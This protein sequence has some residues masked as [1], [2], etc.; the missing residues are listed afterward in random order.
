MIR[1]AVAFLCAAMGIAALSC[2]ASA[3]AFPFVIPSNDSA[4]TAIDVSDLNPAPLDES[5][6]VS[7]RG[8]HFYDATGRRVRFVGTNF[9]AGACFP[10]K[11]DAAE[12]AARLHKYGFNCV[13]L[14]HMDSPW[15]E[16]NMFYVTGGSY[17]R[18]TDQLDPESLDRFD[19]LIYQ[20]KQHGIYVDINLHVGRG[21][22]AAD[23]FPD[24]DR[25][26]DMGKVV[27]YFE[28][29][30]IERQKLYAK[31]L[32]THYNPYT[33]MRY[34]D[35]PVVA[36]IEITNED[37]LLGSAD[38]LASL[39]PHYLGIL[40][41]GWNQ[42]LRDK[43]GSTER[44]VSAWNA[45]ARPLGENMLANPQLLDGTT[46]WTL[47]QH[48]GTHATMVTEAIEAGEGA[49]PG[50]AL[51]LTDLQLDDTGWHLQLHQVGLTLRE[52][53]MYTVSFAARSN[54]SRSLGVNVRLD[55]DPWTMAGLDIGIALTPEWQ[56]HSFTFIARNTVPGH[57]RLSFVFGEA[58]GDVFLADLSLRPG[59][60]Q[61]ELGPG[62]SL[63]AGSIRPASI[64][65]TPRGR[66]W[67]EYLMQVE[68]KF[69][70]GM[71]A[72][73]KE[74]LGARAS[75]ACTQASYG[76]L[77][78]VLRESRLDW[79]DMH[80]YWQHPWFP[81]RPWDSDDYRIGNT[82]MVR[83][84]YG[85]TLPGLAMHRV[86]GKPFTVSEYDHPAPNEWAA[87]M[88]PMIFA[89]AAWQDWD[90]VFTF[91]YH[92]DDQGWDR[93]RIEGFFDQ[94]AH[95]GKLAF[96]PAAAQMFLRGEVPAAPEAQT[97][98]VPQAQVPAIVAERRDYGFWSA[99]EGET[100]SGRDM[101][102]RRTNVRFVEN[103]GGVR[104]ERS[105]SAPGTPALVW[106]PRD[107]AG[108]LFTISSP[109]AKAV[110][111]FAGGRS[112]DVGGVQVAMQ[113]TPRNFLSLT[114]VAK[115]GKPIEASSSLIL[116][117]V[118]KVENA[119]LQW[120]AERT[121]AAQSWQRGPTMAETVAATITIPTTARRASVFALDQ[122]GARSKAVPS[123]LRAGRLTFR[124]G[125]E[126]GAV[127]Y[128]IAASR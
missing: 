78:G 34:V 85:G 58:A 57:V 47:E 26:D 39:P 48:E 93:D 100:V 18:K 19:Y 119:G 110:V 1:F 20:F 91:A 37:S 38:S 25:I 121:Y 120:N 45:E 35:D 69:T 71:Y 99:A 114:L 87:E 44:L 2:A 67:V 66:D 30:M 98:V 84:E 54:V 14:H 90:G 50:R 21:F 109:S 32:L 22:N 124:I 108:A 17:G 52:G 95:P 28:P 40:A 10:S 23:G 61:V 117:S 82:P 24:T 70:R 53:E 113:Q 76:G 63:E 49:P 46:G 4:K 79:V 42:F 13:R 88:V 75:V 73:I 68:E 43:Y 62:E 80:A 83:E 77:G 112:I 16:P 5:R 94:A 12:V 89:Y 51:R 7:V 126:D 6:R 15:S 9:A 101:V 8:D 59:G 92:G 118:D 127:W 104:V 105:G 55:Q 86:A 29:G 74:D 97:L 128:E 115:D 41:E 81:N 36:L 96:M 3:G 33:K 106:R 103:G 125:P 27:G 102:A 31:Q 107:P 56:R 116:T 60:G 122:T 111:G 72:Y 11:Q 64:A 65:A 123:T